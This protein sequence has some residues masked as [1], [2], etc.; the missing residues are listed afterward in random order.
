[1]RWY[2]EVPISRQQCRQIDSV[3]GAE[4]SKTTEKKG[5]RAREFQLLV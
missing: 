1:M 5:W 4:I 2:L 3:I